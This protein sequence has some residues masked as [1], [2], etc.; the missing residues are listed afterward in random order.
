VL[1]PQVDDLIAKKKS[2]EKLD[3]YQLEKISR[4]GELDA[5][6]ALLQR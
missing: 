5:E 2:G 3:V 4:K 6:L 1:G